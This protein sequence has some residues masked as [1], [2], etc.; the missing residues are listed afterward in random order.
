[1]SCVTL[2]IVRKLLEKNVNVTVKRE[3]SFLHVTGDRSGQVTAVVQPHLDFDERFKDLAQ[4]EQNVARRQLQIDVAEL[5]KSWL[6]YKER[7]T[8]KEK[9]VAKKKEITSQMQKYYNSKDK[10]EQLESL[11]FELEITKDAL[12]KASSTVW[13]I[14]NNVVVRAL[15]LPNDI[16]PRVPDEEQIELS[17]NREISGSVD[18][19]VA[20]EKNG[21]LSYINPSCYYLT[22]DLAKLEL[23]IADYFEARFKQRNHQP[24][25]NTDFSR[26]VLVE[27]CTL[28]T[29]ATDL[30]L[31]MTPDSDDGQLYL[32][33]GASFLP[34][35]GL[36]AKHTVTL[37]SPSFRYVT[38]GRQ[39]RTN[40]NPQM[41]GLY[42][43]WQATGV[44]FFIGTST[45]TET[46]SECDSALQFLIEL[47]KSLGLGFRIVNT[48]A[49]KLHKWESLR[50]TFELFSPASQTYAEVGNVSVINDFISKRLQAY[51]MD[52]KNNMGF[53]HVVS[54][55]AVRIPVLLAAA[56]ETSDDHNTVQNLLQKTKELE[57]VQT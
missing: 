16:D 42:S 11:K 26:P 5:S 31:L 56:L 44:E 45:S 43:A 27:G 2:R 1:M 30:S 40:V 7:L 33:G 34:F 38:K 21:C 55:T 17:Y 28:K 29:V 20:G 51:C 48:P 23:S 22:K 36:H 19:I 46:S 39:Y 6:F 50:F 3:C 54:G 52:E 18:H 49:R 8:V 10:S 53:L 32:N 15:Q 37:E 47:Y 35:F 4:L 24:V 25:S 57:I 13:D 12:R 14:E 41:N 9:L